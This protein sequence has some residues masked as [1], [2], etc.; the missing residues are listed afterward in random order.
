MNEV[1]HGSLVNLYPYFCRKLFVVFL[2]F[3]V[4]QSIQWIC[5]FIKHSI[6]LLPRRWRS[7]LECYPHK[8][9]G[10]CSNPAETDLSRKDRWWQLHSQTLVSRCQCHGSSKMI[11]ING[12]P[13][14][15]Y[16]W[17]AKEPSLLKGYEYRA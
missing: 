8:R 13:S 11:I 4:E 7:L 14:S 9:E 1:A 12:C 3:N 2:K 6:F 15:Q 17:H 5:S 10:G 16:M